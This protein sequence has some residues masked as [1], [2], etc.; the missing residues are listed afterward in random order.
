MSAGCATCPV[1]LPVG[2]A[3]PCGLRRGG[4]GR[5]LPFDAGL[6]EDHAGPSAQV[7][8][9]GEG[10]VDVGAAL[11]PLSSCPSGLVEQIIYELTGGSENAGNQSQASCA[12]P[13]PAGV[14]VPSLLQP[15]AASHAG[16]WRDSNSRHTVQNF[17]P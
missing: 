11:D 6:D 15:V 2:S 5:D 9:V 13:P 17:A 3:H 4:G 7:G 14:G 1:A 16:P 8:A 10:A 12:S